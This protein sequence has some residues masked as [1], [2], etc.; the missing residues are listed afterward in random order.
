MGSVLG[1]SE[2]A[3]IVFQKKE[4]VGVKAIEYGGE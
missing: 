3:E 4:V 2:G 1:V